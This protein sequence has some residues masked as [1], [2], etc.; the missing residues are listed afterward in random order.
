[1]EQVV[2][3]GGRQYPHVLEQ[4]EAHLVQVGVL[5]ARVLLVPWAERRKLRTFE[6]WP[7]QVFFDYVDDVLFLVV[8]L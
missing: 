5:L 6:L 8:L 1:M 4:A 3:G 2:L 7:T